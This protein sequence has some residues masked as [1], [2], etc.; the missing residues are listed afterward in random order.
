MSFESRVMAFS[1]RFLSDRAFHL[2]V[3]PALADLQF[4]EETGRRSRVANRVAVLRA[5]AGGLGDDLSRDWDSMFKLTLLST[6]YF[7][8]PI[9]LAIQAFRTWSE[10]LFVAMVVQGLA[11]VPVVVCFW[12]APRTAPPID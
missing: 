2:I 11:L 12:P 4:D 6:C 7:M 1:E 10:F 9:A 8:F 3:E 5:V